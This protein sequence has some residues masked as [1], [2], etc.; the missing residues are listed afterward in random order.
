MDRGLSVRE[1]DGV[2]VGVDERGGTANSLELMIEASSRYLTAAGDS[3]R[4]GA[5]P[6]L[7]GVINW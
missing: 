5:V 3:K 7:L 1:R 2:G 6:L 4:I